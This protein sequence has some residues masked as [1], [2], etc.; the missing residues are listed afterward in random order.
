MT[1]KLFF[2]IKNYTSAHLT[3]FSTEPD[4]DRWLGAQ[5]LC[6]LLGLSDPQLPEPDNGRRRCLKME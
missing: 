6:H 1:L 4:P 2:E 5:S 3:P